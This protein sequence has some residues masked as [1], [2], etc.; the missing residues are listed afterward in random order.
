MNGARV[1]LKI[2]APRQASAYLTRVYQVVCIA[3]VAIQSMKLALAKR[4]GSHMSNCN[5]VIVNEVDYSVSVTSQRQRT[6][7]IE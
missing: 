6:K 5:W 4:A 2:V 7:S 1:D 3:E